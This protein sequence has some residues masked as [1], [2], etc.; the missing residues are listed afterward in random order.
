MNDYDGMKLKYSVGAL[1]YCPAIND[2]IVRQIVG[3]RITP[4]YSAALCLE[5]AI[6]D[7]MV[8]QAEK[9]LL[10]HLQEIYKAYN[11]RSFYL[12]KIFIRVRSGEQAVS[13]YQKAGECRN[14][15]TGFLFPKYT[16]STVDSCHAA[17]LEIN[18]IAS[19]KVYLMPIL[20]SWDILSLSTRQHVLEELRKKT[21]EMYDYILNIR[22]GGNDFCNS[23][24]L[25]RNS[26][27]TI[28]DIG[29]IQS[30][31]ID[32]LNWFSR[33]YVVSA[34]VWEYFDAGISNTWKSTLRREVE[35][36]RLNGFVGK[37][38][39]HPSQIPVVNASM[40]IPRDEYMD[41]CQILQ[42]IDSTKGVEKGTFSGRMNEV[43]CHTRWAEKTMLLA[44]LYGIRNDEKG[45]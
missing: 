5:D 32:I 23:Y 41:A 12:P 3:E 2:K 7:N 20:E 24:R 30:C 27:Q 37:T 17:I 1:L 11:D 19:Q 26:G 21:D 39:I 14:L 9:Q 42:W 6:A 22:V 15:I 34:P 10:H 36:D 8:Q 29:I 25:R 18:R 38:V 13:L 16:L 44:K 40:Q 31:L 43:K 28:Y 35:L 4:P 45:V 33:D